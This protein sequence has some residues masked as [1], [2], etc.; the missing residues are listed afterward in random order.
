MKPETQAQCVKRLNKIK[1]QL[2]GVLRM[3]EKGRPEL[4][5]MQQLKS[6]RAAMLSLQNA[7]L[8]DAVEE[9]FE[10]GLAAG[11]D[12]ARRREAEALLTFLNQS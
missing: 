10:R 6:S 11:T 8:C 3:I 1:G 2:D 4:D 9:G 5:I 7:V 12:T